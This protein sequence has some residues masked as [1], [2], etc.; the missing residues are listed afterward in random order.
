MTLS[1]ASGAVEDYNVLIVRACWFAFI[2]QMIVVFQSLIMLIMV[3]NASWGPFQVCGGL[4]GCTFLIQLAAAIVAACYSWNEVAKG[5]REGEDG[6]K[7]GKML[8]IYAI[9]TVSIYSAVIVIGIIVS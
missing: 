3:H 6:S 2:V 5:C 7:S 9:V 1:L 4:K 8:N